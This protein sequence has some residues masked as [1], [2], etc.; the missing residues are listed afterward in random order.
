MT[1]RKLT[2]VYV[3]V[4][5]M[6][7]ELGEEA[8][9]ANFRG[10]LG[11]LAGHTVEGLVKCG[12]NVIPITFFY[13]KNWQTGENVDYTKTPALR[14]PHK[15][16]VEMH[17]Q[18]MTTPI[19]TINRAGATVFGL[20]HPEH[21]MLYPGDKYTKLDQAA[22]LGRA[23]PALL[24][25]LQIVPDIVWCQEW[26]TG[27]VI[28][29]MRD[30]H[31]FNA[32]KSVFTVHT[33]ARGALERFPVDAYD[34]MAI[35]RRWYNH[36]VIDNAI[37]PTEGGIK[38]ADKVTGVSKQFGEICQMMF[39]DDAHKIH[40]IMNGTSRDFFLS[41]HIKMYREEPN[42]LQL[43]LAHKE[44]KRE[45][46]SFIE[47]RT[48]V[49]FDVNKML[50]GAVRR[51]ASYKNQLPMFVS[52]IDQICAPRP[53]GY[54]VQVLLGGVAHE[55]D[56]ECRQWME[57]LRLLMG[58][59]GLKNRFVYIPE[60]SERFRTLAARGCDLWISCPWEANEACGTSDFV[61]KIDGNPNLA[62]CGG[63]IMEHG[64]EFD[65]TTRQGDT[66]FITPYSA[67]TMGIKAGWAAR[68]YYN[69]KEHGDNTWPTLRMNNFVGGKALDIVHMVARYNEECFKPLLGIV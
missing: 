3:S 59:E 7:P 32:C 21:K 5:M 40:G 22:F 53:H 33:I 39:V 13:T 64:T 51:L 4:E 52:V 38:C 37:K 48:G 62:T 46:I 30:D 12:I 58:R 19:W 69:Y 54:D 27:L 15:L 42:S 67:Q 49:R 56:Y 16:N 34:R 25:H 8:C 68:M 26:M 35:D 28:P 10:G 41:P 23:V 57:E 60:Y 63:G 50:D 44:D 14:H 17:W 11:D 55:N 29:N 45:L 36:F 9:T 1:T 65:H 61:A 31:Q 2:I 18:K 43:E 6:I 66:F 24:G 47:A 20:S